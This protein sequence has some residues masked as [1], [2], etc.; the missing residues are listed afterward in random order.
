MPCVTL[1]WRAGICPPM[2]LTMTTAYIALGSN[3]GQ[4][5]SAL[6]AALAQ[7][8]EIPGTRILAVASFRET[9]PVDC[10]PDTPYFVNSVA[11]IETSLDAAELL[12][13][14]VRIE[15]D[16]G[17]QRSSR[18]H[19]S[20]TID[21]DLLLCGDAVLSAP[22]LIVPH[23]RMHLR[24]FVLEPLTEIAPEVRHPVSGKTARQM[25][26]D[27]PTAPERIAG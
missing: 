3:L 9:A 11:S 4:R 20:R 27:L 2:L 18:L 5:H 14:L 7:I 24:R 1:P 17:R 21:L 6:Q 19:E 16:L 22:G 8:E 12:E 15:R 10:A 26:A 23:P 13:S 25:L